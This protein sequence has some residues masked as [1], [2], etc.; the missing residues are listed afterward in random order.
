MV[1]KRSIFSLNYYLTAQNKLP[2]LCSLAFNELAST[3]ANKVREMLKSNMF[4]HVNFIERNKFDLLIYHT[5]PK[6]LWLLTFLNL[7][8]GCR[9]VQVQLWKKTGFKRL[10][11]SKNIIWPCLCHSQS[12]WV[13]FFD[14]KTSTVGEIEWEPIKLQNGAFVNYDN[15]PI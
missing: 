1:W 2:L 7:S 12:V 8:T 10:S 4:A 11:D 3:Y 5:A 13:A 15:W 9:K 6:S 14:I